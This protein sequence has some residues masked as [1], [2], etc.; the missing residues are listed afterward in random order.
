[1]ETL[2]FNGNPQ[3]HMTVVLQVDKSILHEY[4]ER[5]SAYATK[6]INAKQPFI[7]AID[8]RNSN[9]EIDQ[10]IELIRKVGTIHEDLY[11]RN[12][13]YVDFLTSVIIVLPNTLMAN[14]LS[15][16][17]HSLFNPLVN[18]RIVGQDDVNL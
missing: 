18:L 8:L 13:Q 11:Q 10:N 6:R 9:I 5:V 4:G 3:L 12:K 15:I 7:M 2:A 16:T 1:M 14:A 17:V